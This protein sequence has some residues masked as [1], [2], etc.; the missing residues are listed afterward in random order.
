[1]LSIVFSKDRPLQLDAYLKSFRHNCLG[2]VEPVVVLK[3]WTPEYEQVRDENPRVHWLKEMT[4]DETFRR[5]IKKP[6]FGD[7]I[8]QINVDDCVWTNPWCP[9]VCEDMMKQFSDIDMIDL[10][11]GYV[12]H[13]QRWITGFTGDVHRDY[14]F[15]ISGAI[16]RMSDIRTMLESKNP[17][18][19]PND[20]ECRGVLEFGPR[21]NLAAITSKGCNIAQD[22]NVV[23]D[24]YRNGCNGNKSVED[25]LRWYREGK[26]IDWKSVQGR[27]GILVGEEGWKLI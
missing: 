13:S 26:R 16:H 9:A 7:F 17:F 10:R 5:L 2:D 20:I 6:P 11:H 4:F 22:V 15:N 3:E 14:P 27:E 18:E 25:C 21:R 8:L 19:V 12:D 23:Q 24:K 1:M